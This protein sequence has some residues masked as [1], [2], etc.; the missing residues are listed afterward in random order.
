ML[1]LILFCAELWF[2]PSPHGNLRLRGRVRNFDGKFNIRKDLFLE[3]VRGSCGDGK[4]CMKN[5]KFLV[6]LNSLV[7]SQIQ[8]LLNNNKKFLPLSREEK[9]TPQIH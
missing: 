2:F 7:V 1:L 5:L 4:K 3:F 9:K 6:F 8:L